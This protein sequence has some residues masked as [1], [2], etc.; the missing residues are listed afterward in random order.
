M[1]AA[2]RKG[3]PFKNADNEAKAMAKRTALL[4][5]LQKKALQD[6]KFAAAARLAA[7]AGG[8]RKAGRKQRQPAAAGAKRSRVASDLASS[9]PKRATPPSSPMSGVRR[10]ALWTSAGRIVVWQC[11]R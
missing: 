6:K 11:V 2:A 3:R 4:A 7:A 5:D 1:D 9:S 10:G 8:G